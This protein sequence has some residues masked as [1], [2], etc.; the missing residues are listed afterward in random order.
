MYLLNVFYWIIQNP[1]SLKNYFNNPFKG[2]GLGLGW[3][4]DGGNSL[5]HGGNSLNNGGNS[6][7]SIGGV[8]PSESDSQ[9]R[10]GDLNSTHYSYGSSGIAIASASSSGSSGLSN[11]DNQ[12]S[13]EITKKIDDVAVFN[14]QTIVVLV[15]IVL[16]LLIIGYKRKEHND[17]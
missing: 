7:N 11:G 2:T 6:L 8:N 5:T 17:E 1:D 16:I 15:G 12:Q 4:T 3:L 13:Y 10:K 14:V 9:S